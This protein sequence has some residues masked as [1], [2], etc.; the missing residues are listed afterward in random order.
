MIIGTT[1]VQLSYRK[2]EKYSIQ[3]VSEALVGLRIIR[4]FMDFQKHFRSSTT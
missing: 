4:Q 2:L 1:E 3:T